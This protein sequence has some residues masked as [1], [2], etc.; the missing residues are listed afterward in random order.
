M[1]CRVCEHNT[2]HVEVATMLATRCIL[3]NSY[4][5]N[6]ERLTAAGDDFIAPDGSV[7]KVVENTP[8]KAVFYVKDGQYAGY[9]RYDKQTGRKSIELKYP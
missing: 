9:Y 6:I 8:Q 5:G 1:Y 7:A 3:C 4:T 2:P